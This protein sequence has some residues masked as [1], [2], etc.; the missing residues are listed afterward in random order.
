MRTRLASL[1]VLRLL[2]PRVAW[3]WLRARRLAASSGD[4]FSQASVARVEELE[5]LLT[6]ARG[7]R[8][9]AEIGTGT[10]WTAIALA[11]DDG[12]RRVLTLDPVARAERERYLALA[13][14]AASRIELLT[15]GGETGPRAG[16]G[17]FDFV[18]VDSSHERAETIATFRAWEPAVAPGGVVVFH[19]YGSPDYPGV[20]E[21]IADLGLEGSA[22]PPLFVWRK[23]R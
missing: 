5:R 1:L 2:P 9:V 23:P 16:G 10:A 11:L 20:A 7:R 3:F 18:F 12:S 6:L 21:A 15:E 17:P 8:A 14:R 4:T 19:D 22:E 13:G